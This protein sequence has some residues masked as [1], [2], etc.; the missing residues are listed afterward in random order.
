MTCK[1]KILLTSRPHALNELLDDTFKECPR[2]RLEST[3]EKHTSGDVERFVQNE[4][5]N[6][7]RKEELRDLR[8]LIPCAASRLTKVLARPS[9]IFQML[10][11]YET[12]ILFNSTQS[13]LRANHSNSFP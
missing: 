1:F 7:S 5:A 13:Y 2:I 9:T 10:L 12:T 8:D 6:L 4:F 11:H 3:D